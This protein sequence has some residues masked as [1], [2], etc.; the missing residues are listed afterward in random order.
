MVYHCTCATTFIN[1]HKFCNI[2]N[3]NELDVVSRKKGI[4]R[5]LKLDLFCA[6]SRAATLAALKEY[7]T[8]CTSASVQT[9]FY[10]ES[11]TWT[12]LLDPEWKRMKT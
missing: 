2:K 4:S 5:I 9:S 7:D 10:S 3:T 6:K 12:C 8:I 1:I 11:T